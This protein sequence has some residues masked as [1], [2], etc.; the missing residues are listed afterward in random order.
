MGKTRLALA[1]MAENASYFVDGLA[2]IPLAAIRDPT[3]VGATIAKA[4][5]LRETRLPLEPDEN[6]VTT[7][8]DMAHLLGLLAQ[9]K[10]LSDDSRRELR[11][12]LALREPLDP[13]PAALPAGTTILSKTGNLERASN[14]AGLVVTPTGPI[15]LAVFDE[16]VDPGDARSTIAQLAELVYE[17]FAH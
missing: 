14:V 8:A 1:V 7:A 12:L 2:F 16:D 15:I 4:L 6:S 13:L 17:H 9:E 3:L 10:I 5:G 11:Q